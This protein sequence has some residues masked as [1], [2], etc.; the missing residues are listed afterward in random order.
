MDLR[1]KGEYVGQHIGWCFK[2][3]RR[4]HAGSVPGLELG[5]V[6]DVSVCRNVS[7]G[8]RAAMVRGDV[9][10]ERNEREKRKEKNASKKAEKRAKRK[11][12]RERKEAE[13]KARD[14]AA[15]S[16]P[17]TSGARNDD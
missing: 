4:A 1:E 8:G 5:V 2:I 15:T 10:I 6:S 14:Q 3:E 7:A 9:Q 11:V 12:N 16:V 17:S 13:A